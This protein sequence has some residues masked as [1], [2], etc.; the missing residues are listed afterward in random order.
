MLGNEAIV[1]ESEATIRNS[2]WTRWHSWRELCW[3]FVQ[4][5]QVVCSRFVNDSL[6]VS[7]VEMVSNLYKAELWSGKSEQKFARRN[8][9]CAVMPKMDF[10]VIRKR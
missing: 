3:N 1:L 6:K 9:V 7:E 10:N 2:N 4:G 5:Q 8:R